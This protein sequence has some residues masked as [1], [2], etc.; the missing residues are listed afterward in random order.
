MYFNGK[1]KGT[2]KHCG[3]LTKLDG[4]TAMCQNCSEASPKMRR[5]EMED[6]KGMTK[7]YPMQKR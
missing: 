7:S 3:M 2:C 6:N 5:K 4:S 1:N